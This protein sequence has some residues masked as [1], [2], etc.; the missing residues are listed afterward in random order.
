MRTQR[1]LTALAVGSAVV[2][3]SGMFAVGASAGTETTQPTDTTSPADVVETTVSPWPSLP[4]PIAPPTD[5]DAEPQIYFGRILI[6][7]IDVDAP[8][9]EGIRLST[10]DNGPGHWPGTAMPGELGNVVVA[11][12]RTSHNADFRRLDELEVG[13]EV[14][15]DLDNDESI[16][17]DQPVPTNPPEDVPT[18]LD[19]FGLPPYR[20]PDPTAY[21]GVYVYEVVKVEI[22]PPTAMWIVTQDYRH[23]ATLFAC[24]PPGSVAERIVVFLDLKDPAPEPEDPPRWPGFFGTTVPETL[25]GFSETTTGS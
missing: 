1:R 19:E 5:N 17:G 20:L 9:I 24:H 7:A 21:S 16:F 3:C 11:G 2:L 12:H 15:F 8:F 23:E 25:P 10:L 22:V 18:T 6:P 4:Q 13:D 14:I